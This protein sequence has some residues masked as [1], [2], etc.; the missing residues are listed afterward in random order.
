MNNRKLSNIISDLLHLLKYR[1]ITC[2]I[3]KRVKRIVA[4]PGEWRNNIHFMKSK[5][6]ITKQ[7]LNQIIF[8]WCIKEN[9]S[10]VNH[11]FS[12]KMRLTACKN[13]DPKK[14]LIL[15]IWEIYYLKGE[16]KWFLLSNLITWTCLKERN[17]K[18][19]DI[20]SL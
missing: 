16:Q 5:R 15:K 18:G 6:K 3:E 8:G 13:S 17:H 10:S 20:S 11:T 4:G 14:K 7:L 19:F 9:V 2:F 12:P 1:F